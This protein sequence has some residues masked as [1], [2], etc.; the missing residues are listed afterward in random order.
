MST[1]AP[2]NYGID[3]PS[4][5]AAFTESLKIGN[6][7]STVQAVNDQR[8]LM[9]QVMENINSPSATAED[10]ARLSAFLPKE[11]GDNLRSAGKMLNESQQQGVLDRS[12]KIFAA[13]KLN[14][15]EI[16]IDLI[17]QRATELKNSGDVQ[18]AQF[19]ETLGKVAEYDQKSVEA[20]FGHT[21]S[22]LPGGD[23]V[24]ESAV[25]LGAEGRA[26]NREPTEMQ[27][28]TAEARIK[29]A[30]A[31][32]AP[33]KL[34]A[35]LGLVK[36]QIGAS[37][38]SAA[39]SYASAEASK[40]NAQKI[41]Q[42]IAGG[43]APEKRQEIESKFRKEYSDQTK[44]Y[45]DVKASYARIKESSD[46]AV[47]DLS[48]IFGYMKMLDPS[49]TVREGEFATAQNAA[50]A[51]D[52]V[53]N[54]YNRIVSGERLTP[55]QRKSFVGQAERL[56]KAAGV[57]ENIVRKGIERIASSYGLK[58]DNIFYSPTEVAP[59]SSTPS[60]IGTPPPGV[61]QNQ[62]QYMTP[63]QRALWQ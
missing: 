9:K 17:K 10:Y 21:L 7:I 62:W 34:A 2:I 49:S 1:Q 3:V 58:P 28:I 24:I 4:P 12:S 56:Y 5:G 44:S 61:T 15:P 57:Q 63:E 60:N 25:K 11:A 29:E 43:F 26:A 35:D 54:I 32:L 53:G 16:A 22:Q 41:R 27:K 31:N 47:G 52:R 19:V 38:A 48:L 55:S 39:A 33:E 37:K 18:G 42:E 6:N 36:A 30:E 51:F 50:G 13:F 14:N 59:T 8:L 40:S 46:D 20:F 23:K 45:Q